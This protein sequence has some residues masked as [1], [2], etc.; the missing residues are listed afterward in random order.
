M[1]CYIKQNWAATAGGENGKSKNEF[2]RES[3]S[4]NKYV[5]H[6]SSYNPQSEESIQIT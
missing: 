2:L 4:N 1:N 6:E 3:D 5:Y